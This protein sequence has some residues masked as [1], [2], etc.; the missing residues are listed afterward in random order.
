MMSK[1]ANFIYRTYAADVRYVGGLND[2]CNGLINGQQLATM[3]E[4]L[5]RYGKWIW[6]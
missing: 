6:I 4:L 1:A 5:D 2:T 3:H